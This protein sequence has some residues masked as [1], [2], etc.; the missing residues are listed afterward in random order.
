MMKVE[1][2]DPDTGEYLGFV[3]GKDKKECRTLAYLRWNGKGHRWRC[4][5]RTSQLSLFA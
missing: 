5:F 1:V 4:L 3:K 2:V